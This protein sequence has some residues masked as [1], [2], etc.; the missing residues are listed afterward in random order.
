MGM[1]PVNMI[2]SKGF[3]KSVAK[4]GIKDAAI[5][6]KMKI[7]DT[8]LGVEKAAFKKIPLTTPIIGPWLTERFANRAVEAWKQKQPGFEFS[9][10]QMLLHPPTQPRWQTGFPLFDQSRLD[11]DFG[12]EPAHLVTY[13][14]KSLLEKYAIL[15]PIVGPDMAM[16]IVNKGMLFSSGPLSRMKM[17]SPIFNL[18]FQPLSNDREM[19]IAGQEFGYTGVTDPAIK[20]ILAGKIESLKLLEQKS[21]E[22]NIF[23]K[24]ERHTDIPQ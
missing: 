12:V 4:Q 22:T 1:N 15:E 19:P 21:Q 24:Q 3:M 14:D 2:F 5:F 9:L 18:Q 11:L 20:S 13:E 10:V 17:S 6:G 8:A 23:I 16:R 7:L